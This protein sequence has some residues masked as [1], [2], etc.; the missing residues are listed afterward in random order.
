MKK[1]DK[2]GAGRERELISGTNRIHK[3]FRSH[4]DGSTAAP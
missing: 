3:I 1:G 2:R 4:Y